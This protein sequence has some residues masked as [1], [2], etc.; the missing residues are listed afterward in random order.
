MRDP[1]RAVAERLDARLVARPASVEFFTGAAGAERPFAER[2][3]IALD[4][5]LDVDP[6]AARRDHHAGDPAPGVRNAGAHAAASANPAVGRGIE[7]QPEALQEGAAR[8]KLAPPLRGAKPGVAAPVARAELAQRAGERQ[9]V[10]ARY[11][12]ADQRRRMRLALVPPK[13]R[14]LLIT[15][16]S[17]AVRVLSTIGS[18]RTA[19]SGSSRLA[20]AAMKPPS[21]ISRQ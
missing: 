2:I 19:G 21:I 7:P 15:A 1:R 12:Y 6:G 17:F 8:Q 13:P 16:S 14:L 11:G 20:Q 3:E 10:D 5:R 18:P 4:H 9:R